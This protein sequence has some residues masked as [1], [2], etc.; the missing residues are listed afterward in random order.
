MQRR[1]GSSRHPLIVRAT[2]IAQGS[3]APF[4]LTMSDFNEVASSAPSPGG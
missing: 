4:R 2:T 1:L 3:S